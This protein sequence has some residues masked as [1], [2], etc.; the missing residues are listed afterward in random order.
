[1]HSGSFLDKNLATLFGIDTDASFAVLEHTFNLFE[2]SNA[3]ALRELRELV[4]AL[5][6]SPTAETMEA[7]Q[8]ASEFTDDYEM[9]NCP[10]K[11]WLNTGADATKDLLKHPEEAWLGVGAVVSTTSLSI[12]A[13]PKTDEP[14]QA[15]KGI[16]ENLQFFMQEVLEGHLLIGAVGSR[17]GYSGNYY[18]VCSMMLVAVFDNPGRNIA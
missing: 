5:V 11:C 6:A 15:A 9:T 14:D 2:E 3:P 16:R 1:M 7:L 18:L 13:D 8:D 10:A 4:I 12:G 17:L